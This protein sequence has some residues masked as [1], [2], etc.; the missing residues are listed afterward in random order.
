MAGSTNARSFLAAHRQAARV[1]VLLL[2]MGAVAAPFVIVA[3]SGVQMDVLTYTM[4]LGGLLAF[5]LIFMN[6]VTG[7]MSR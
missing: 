5:T 6:L 7:P 2:G 3:V 4:R 1:V